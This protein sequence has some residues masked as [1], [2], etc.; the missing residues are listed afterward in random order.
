MSDS[1]GNGVKKRFMTS[2]SMDMGYQR[3]SNLVA[4]SFGFGMRWTSMI[5]KEKLNSQQRELEKH[6]LSIKRYLI[7][8]ANHKFYKHSL[9]K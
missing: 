4:G 8:R 2:S 7:D 6:D 9:S 1:L 3:E 5:W